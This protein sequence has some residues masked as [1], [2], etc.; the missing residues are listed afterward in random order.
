MDKRQFNQQVK[1]LFD[2]CLDVTGVEAQQKIMQSSEYSDDV[3]VRVRSL[4]K[5]QNNDG[6]LLEQSIIETAKHGLNSYS[7]QTG[8]IIEQYLLINPIGEGGQGEVWL[9]QRNDGEFNHNVAIKFIKISHNEKELQRFQSERELL[10]SLQHGN[11]A[12]LI[13]GGRLNDRLYMIMEWVDGVP[14]IQYLEKKSLSLPQTLKLF[15]QICQAVSFAH[16][17]G[18]IHRDIKPS[19][20]LVDKQGAIKLL[21]FGIAKTV[22]A[23]VTQNQS[24]TMM[25]LAY[26]SPEQIKGQTISTATDIYA[27]GLILYEL[28]TNHRAQN[29][30]AESA[31]EYVRIISDITPVKPSL[32]KPEPGHSF[33]IKKLQ[34][35]L[36]NLVM[37][38]IRK[39]PERRYKNVDAFIID[40]ENYLQKKPLLASGDSWTYKTSKLLKRNPLTSMLVIAVLAFLIGLPIIM[41][42][43][44][45][46]LK[47]ETQKA[48][49]QAEIAN[50]T[51]DFITTLLK[52]AT[53]LANKG[54]DLNMADVMKQA[55]QDLLAGSIKNPQV[56]VKLYRI[57]ASIQHS[58][59]NNP[60]SIKHY[61]KAADIS[62]QLGNYEGQL[63]SLGQKAVMYFFNNEV[64]NGNEAF[65]QADEVSKKVTNPV[66]L[67]WHNLRKSTNEY[68]KGNYQLALDLAQNALDEMQ[69]R[70]NK[71]PEIL[72][73]IYNELAIATSEFDMEKSLPYRDKA[74]K[75]AEIF[76]GKLHPIYLS[77]TSNKIYSLLKL[78]RYDEAEVLLVEAMELCEKLFTKDHPK[79]AFL[80]SHVTGLH[81]KQGEYDKAKKSRIQANALF[82]KFYGDI[83]FNHV[84]GV[85]AL[86]DIYEA[87]GKYIEAKKLYQR[88]IEIRTT[89]DANNLIRIVKPQKYLARL[90]VKTGDY[91]AA[92]DL[93]S[94]VI[95][96]HDKHK[97]N[98]L[99][100]YIIK[101]AA[102]IGDGDVR[103]QCQLGMKQLSGLLPELNTKPVSNW[104]PML[105]EIWIAELAMKCKSIT[106]AKKNIIS[107]FEKSKKVYKQDSI[108]QKLIAKRVTN[109]LEKINTSL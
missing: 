51:S 66:E 69:A 15:L 5:H 71:N 76:H 25:T 52:S 13:G 8:D 77:R 38:S 24:A 35:D 86:G 4:L 50:A 36:D 89:L 101:A 10:A 28:L 73:R 17:K 109:V 44:S 33:P 62:E 45:V 42:D 63:S 60:K 67:A 41:Y 30:T 23:E 99:Y 92:L 1:S 68:K 105:A 9:A 21:D 14:L 80:L 11:I 32:A 64:D 54:E 31:A 90:M 85:T 98:N 79:Y 43:A 75:Y 100:N 95:E 34:G 22:D 53:P 49:E 91:K 72:G 61:Q 78:D 97:K 48:T 7:V 27:L 56:E 103:S 18:I 3:K 57:F 58:L 102:I 88:A 37:M 19:N 87:Q 39:E 12:G 81:L 2:L 94:Y 96:V 93:I 107:G 82:K 104:E 106:I 59:E 55:E 108:G 47:A 46:K 40:I 70:N 6:S 83:S 20:I 16:S 29:H 84:F 26:S 74:L 65:R